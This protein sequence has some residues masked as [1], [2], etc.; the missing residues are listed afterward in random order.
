[1]V[2]KEEQK[3]KEL[4]RA[5]DVSVDALLKKKKTKN[6]IF[7]EKKFKFRKKILKYK[8]SHSIRKIY[9]ST[10]ILDITSPS[11]VMFV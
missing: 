4:Q 5:V 6:N 7:L 3:E 10:I 1:M 2:G 9:A 11:D 8:L